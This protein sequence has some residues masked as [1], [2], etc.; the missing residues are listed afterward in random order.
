MNKF[1][2]YCRASFA[3]F[4]LLACVTFSVGCSLFS[5]APS[6]QP[7]SSSGAAS[8][9]VNG[10]AITP[11]GTTTAAVGSM[12]LN[13][14]LSPDGKY[15]VTTSSGMDSYL[16]SLRVSDG[17]VVDSISYATFDVNS[18]NNGLFYGLVF[19]PTPNNNTY[20][21][22]AAQGAFGA[23]AV[24]TLG[25]DGSLTQTRTIPANP[26]AYE[27][28]D[29]PAGI[30]LANGNIYITNYISVDLQSSYPPAD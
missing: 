14:V 13:I 21:L 16:C 8:I 28:D 27:P 5:A 10:R 19:D 30:A 15:A 18:P 9:L 17:S 12:P 23:V 20:T 2:S 11:A 1:L 3:I 25:S 26:K 7:A 22:Y 29:Q 24:L 4:I 6:G